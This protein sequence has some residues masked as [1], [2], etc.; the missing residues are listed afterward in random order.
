VFAAVQDVEH[1]HRQHMCI[2]AAEVAVE[3]HAERRCGRAG[4]RQRDT[5]DGIG[6]ELAL[7]WSTVQRNQGEVDPALV[8]GVHAHQRLGDGLIHV[9]DGLEHTL[10]AEPLLVPVAQLQGLVDARGGAGRHHG[11]AD[12]A[13]GQRH[14]HRDRRAPA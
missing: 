7:V 1:R 4:A 2:H 8:A 12:S 3:R 9:P 10:S 13:I 5:E 11:L 14:F 6:A